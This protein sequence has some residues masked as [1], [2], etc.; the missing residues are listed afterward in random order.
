[1]TNYDVIWS[2]VASLTYLDILEYLEE[3]WPESVTENFIHRT[4]TVI[5]HISQNPYFYSY[6]KDVE[7]YKCVVVKQVS[8][9][10]HVENN[11]AELLIFWDN[12]QDPEKLFSSI[13][14]L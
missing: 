4:E 1:M 13:I 14:K 10:Y 7:I 6:S 8:L 9:Y 12:R 11:K 5:N 2:P 3:N